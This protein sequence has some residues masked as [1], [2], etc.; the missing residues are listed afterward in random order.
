MKTL[1]I[2]Q[3]WASLVCTGIKDVENRSWKTPHRGKILIHASSK[4]VPSTFFDSEPIEYV[5]EIDS[6]IDFGNILE[7][8]DLP[9][10][11]IIGYVDIVDCVQDDESS[12]WSEPDCFNWL[13]AEAYVFD[14]P[15][16]NV[17]GKLNLFDY[18][19]ID[20]NNL[21]PAHK[22]DLRKPKRE[23]DKCFQPL[24]NPLF[25]DLLS[26]ETELVFELSNSICETYLD[27]NQAVIPIKTIEFYNE[28]N[29]KAVFEVK[30]A[31]IV[32]PYDENDNSIRV[33]SFYSD[34]DDFMVELE[35]L[36]ITVGKKL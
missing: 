25:E 14:D 17:K 33:F 15:I 1:S 9:T 24:N 22:V 4:K 34:S 2:Q 36:R 21:P 30:E 27:D 13:L 7:I 19:D 26:G 11:A 23:G 16:T 6:N 35:V 32:I 20:E 28:N 12:T 8:E 10:S 31:C 18:P 29:E 3:P 5:A